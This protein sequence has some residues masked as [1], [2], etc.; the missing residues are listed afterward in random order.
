MREALYLSAA[1]IPIM[2]NPEYRYRLLLTS[3]VMYSVRY[4]VSFSYFVTV[5]CHISMAFASYSLIG[6]AKIGELETTA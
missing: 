4:L 1:P 3:L 2:T 6:D 5:S